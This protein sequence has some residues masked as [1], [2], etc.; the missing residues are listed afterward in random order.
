MPLGTFCGQLVIGDEI[1]AI[2]EIKI[3]KD[4]ETVFIIIDQG[5]Y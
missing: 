2:N 5:D 3:E 4:T 1:F